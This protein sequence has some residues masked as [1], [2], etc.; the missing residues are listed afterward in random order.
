M[1]AKKTKSEKA[2]RRVQVHVRLWPAYRQALRQTALDRNLT[3]QDL[4][5]SAVRD[6]L[7]K[8]NN[9]GAK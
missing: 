2:L 6:L 5:E 9:R 3:V 8:E 4:L 7:R 1:P